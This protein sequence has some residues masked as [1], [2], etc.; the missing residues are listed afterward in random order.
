MR[1]IELGGIVGPEG[2]GWPRLDLASP[3][4]SGLVYV[5]E[6]VRQHF[7]D[8]RAE[9]APDC[10]RWPQGT[11]CCVEEGDAILT[12][13]A[14]PHSVWNSDEFACTCFPSKDRNGVALLSVLGLRPPGQP[15]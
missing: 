10:T 3:S 5:P 8:E 11:Q 14:I 6:I 12:M 4:R 1:Q 15:E 9:T 7:L 13:H 2:P